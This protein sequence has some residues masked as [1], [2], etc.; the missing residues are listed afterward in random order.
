MRRTQCPSIS[1]V[2]MLGLFLLGACQGGPRSSPEGSVRSFL[3]A[4]AAQ[5]RAEVEASFTAETR[6]LV[7]EV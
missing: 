2:D 5:D 1:P 3:D 7:A 6:Q 4:L